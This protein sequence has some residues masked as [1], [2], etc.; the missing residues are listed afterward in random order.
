[1]IDPLI[2]TLKRQLLVQEEILYYMDNLKASV[3]YTEM[4][5]DVH[6]I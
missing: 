5:H 2:K 6:M 3:D 1:M 4:G